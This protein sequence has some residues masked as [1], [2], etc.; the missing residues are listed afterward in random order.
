MPS[1]T[2]K[3]PPHGW[4][5][6]IFSHP[7]PR[8]LLPV[9]R[10]SDSLAR[11]NTERKPQSPE[12]FMR[13]YFD[14]R[15]A[16]ERREQSG[17]APFRR[18]FHADDCQWDSRAGILEMMQTENLLEVSVAENT[19]VAITTRQLA[20]APVEHE[21]RLRYHLLAGPDGWLIQSVDFW[22]Q[23]CRGEKGHTDCFFCHGTGWTDLSAFKGKPPE[24]KPKP[25][26]WWDTSR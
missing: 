7:Q 6:V 5:V 20:F 23:S 18:K 16:D 15:V 1:R 9:R 19:A 3:L 8:M 10:W 12:E 13:Q 25:K 2:P 22:C 17:R 24:P 21:D 11:M 26:S 14:E 4:K